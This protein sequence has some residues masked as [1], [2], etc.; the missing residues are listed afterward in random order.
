[1]QGRTT[2][3]DKLSKAC[4]SIRFNWE[5]DSNEIDESD[6]HDEKHSEQRIS[7]SFGIITFDDLEKL[8]INL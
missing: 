4:D 5:W 2:G 6:L 8:R 7:I 3:Q 1:V